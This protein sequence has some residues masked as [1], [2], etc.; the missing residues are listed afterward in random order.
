[1]DLTLQNEG[2]LFRHIATDIRFENIKTR[3]YT[4]MYYIFILFTAISQW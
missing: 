1:M 3:T 2:C 4:C